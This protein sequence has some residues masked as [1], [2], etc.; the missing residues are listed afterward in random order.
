[1]EVNRK[2]VPLEIASR[3]NDGQI[4]FHD[5]ASVGV[6]EYGYVAA[7][8]STRILFTGARLRNTT[9]AQDKFKILHGGNTKRQVQV[10][11]N[12][13]RVISHPLTRRPI[14][15]GNV[16]FKTQNGGQQWEVN[17]SGFVKRKLGCAGKHR[18]LQN[19]I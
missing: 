9:N 15:A 10:H 19:E 3:S 7:I 4:T 6:E 2:T 16:I 18:R 5:W 17:K 14:F 8:R 1:M 11:P 12:C 13:S